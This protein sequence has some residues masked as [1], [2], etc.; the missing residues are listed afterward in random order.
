MNFENITVSD[1]IRLGVSKMRNNIHTYY[2][3][4]DDCF[5]TS[6]YLTFYSLNLPYDFDNQI[7]Y[8]SKITKKEFNNILNLFDKRIKKRIPTVYLTN[9]YWFGPLNTNFYIDKNVYIPRSPIVHF[10]ENLVKD[11][12]NI[13]DLCC[14]S[15][16][17]GIIASLLNDKCLVDLADIDEKTLKVSQKNIDKHN[18]KTKV[19]CIKSDLFKNVNKKYDL[20]IAV[21]PQVSKEEYNKRVKESLH[22]PNLAYEASDNGFFYIKK[23]IDTSPKFLNENGILFMEVGNKL[24][25]KIKELYPDLKLEWYKFNGKDSILKYTKSGKN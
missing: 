15:G 12:K 25:K 6:R 20:I 5:V 4:D 14:G 17:L 22:E 10:L 23:I 2:F 9:E 24:P 21:P 1:V 8:N 16:A 7:Y 3:G 13:L 18:L 19:K 11:K